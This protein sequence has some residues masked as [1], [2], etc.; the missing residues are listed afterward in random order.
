MLELCDSIAHF[1]IGFNE[2]IDMCDI[3]VD[4]SLHQ[5]FGTKAKQRFDRVKNLVRELFQTYSSKG[6]EPDVPSMGH[7]GSNNHEMPSMKTDPWA[8]WDR[9]LSHDLQSQ[10]TIELDIWRRTQFP[11]LQN[12]TS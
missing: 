12:L 7:L 11:V 10:K 9:Q 5:S 1:A 8:A 6:K 2:D 4:N 3:E